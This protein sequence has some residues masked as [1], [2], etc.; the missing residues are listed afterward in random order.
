MLAKYSRLRIKWVADQTLTYNDGARILVRLSPWRYSA[1]VPEYGTTIVLDD[2]NWAVWGAGQTIVTTGE[3]E[4]DVVDNTSDL[5]F[6]FK[7]YLE[8]IA[9]VSSTDGTAYLYLEESDDDVNWPSDQADFDIEKH[10]RLI[11]TLEF[12]TDAVDE[13]A[14]T[15][16]DIS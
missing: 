13:S 16:F 8:M 11:S 7:G 5:D 2:D 3:V 12:S 10:L 6:G 14:A 15:N 1:G 9:D 4:S